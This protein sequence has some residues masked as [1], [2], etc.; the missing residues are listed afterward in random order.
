MHQLFLGKEMCPTFLANFRGV[1]SLERGSTVLD[2]YVLYH[3]T[4]D[5]DE[6][7]SRAELL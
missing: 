6:S 5:V 4:S 3:Y 7:A 1:V 2:S